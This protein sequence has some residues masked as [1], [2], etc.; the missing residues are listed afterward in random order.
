M[1]VSVFEVSRLCQ[2]LN[3]VFLNATELDLFLLAEHNSESCL[4]AAIFLSKNLFLIYEAGRTF[5]VFTYALKYDLTYFLSR[6]VFGSPIF[7]LVPTGIRYLKVSL[8][9]FYHGNL[10]NQCFVRALFQC[11]L[12]NTSKYLLNS[13]S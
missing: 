13:L 5:F 4:F 2:I 7:C 1:L 10:L 11:G 9:N 12:A 3:T 6:V 8:S